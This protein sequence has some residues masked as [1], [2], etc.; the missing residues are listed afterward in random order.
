MIVRTTSYTNQSILNSVLEQ[1]AKLFDAYNKINS[2]KKFT[3]ISENPIDASSVIGLNNQLNRIGSYVKNIQTATTQINVQD[4]AFSTTIDK[5]QR[6][7]DL[8]IQ[9]ANGAGGPESIKACQTEI[10]ELKKS[11][12]ALANTEY[13]GIYIFAGA[14]SETVPYTY[15]EE[16]GEILYNGTPG[17]DPNFE[18]K[19]EISEG[20]KI[21]INAAGDSVFGAYDPANPDDPD[22]SYGLFK[23]LGDLSTA[24][25]NGDQEA[26]RAQLDNIQ[27][28]IDHVSETQ[29][30]F[31]ASVAKLEMTQTNLENT[32]LAL[33]SQ[34]QNLEEIEQATAISNFLKENYAY[35]ASMQVFMQ[36]Q[37]NSL[38]NYM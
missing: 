30:I 29:S 31:S 32:E 37:N 8:A 20:V 26:I 33:T 11:I 5:L 15:N 7:N 38:M 28:S 23:V 17:S 22:S 4:T 18:R 35:Q 36:M 25:E 24:L 1:E 9:A 2:N 34:K 16:T 19:L 14:N 21:G 27:G 6:I 13:N 10:E 3:N 12:V